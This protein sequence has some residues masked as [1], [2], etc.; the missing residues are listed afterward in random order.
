M[1]GI[2]PK[3]AEELETQG[4][5]CVEDLL[6]HIPFRYEDRS[7]F[8]PIAHLQPGLRATVR[9]RVVTGTLR[10]TRVR[11]FS[12]FEAIVEDG[13]GSI[14]A[15]FF[16]QPYLRTL[17]APGREVVLHGQAEIS[18]YRGRNL[19]L[20]A[21]Q[22]EVLSAG[23]DDT[24]HTGRMV[25]IYGRLPGLSSRMIRRAVHSILKMLPDVLLDP[26]PMG[27]AAKR[28]FPDRRAAFEGVHFPP[29]GCD[30]DLL[31]RGETAAHRRLI[32]EEFFFLQLG[33]A[34]SRSASDANG[35]AN[36]LRVDGDIRSRLHRALPFHLTGAQNH[37]E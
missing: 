11:G 32:F 22:F 13:S 20:Q 21:P 29:E 14:R 3:R 30:P 4:L 18:R 28:R 6:L 5:R 2:G 23:D 27:V 26:L 34:I 10:R 15:V 36:P 33:F 8:Y 35:R 24:I 1:K 31:A 16:N 7:R 12:I 17:L 19:V 37:P 9:G 25:P